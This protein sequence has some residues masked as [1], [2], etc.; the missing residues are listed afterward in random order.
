MFDVLP[1]PDVYYDLETHAVPFF[2]Y[3]GFNSINAPTQPLKLGPLPA[4]DFSTVIASLEPIDESYVAVKPAKV[5]TQ[6]EVT[7]DLVE[8]LN[9]GD[10]IDV[11]MDGGVQRGS[12]VLK[13]LSLGAKAVGIGRYY[14]YPLPASGQAGVERALGLLRAEIERDMKL[15]GCTV[16]GQLSRDNLRF[17]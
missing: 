5:R 9:V 6:P 2:Q 13:A 1:L 3:L 11:L 16:I 7:A 8:T 10:R 15:M 12:H 17:R 14:L 4:A